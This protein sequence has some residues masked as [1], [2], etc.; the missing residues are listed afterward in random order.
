MGTG[1]SIRRADTGSATSCELNDISTQS[2]PNRPTHHPE[3]PSWRTPTS[4]PTDRATP[5]SDGHWTPQPSK[6]PRQIIPSPK[7]SRP[8]RPERINKGLEDDL[9]AR[10][11]ARPALIRG[12]RQAVADRLLRLAEFL[13]APDRTLIHAILADGRTRVEM[14]GLMGTRE[15][16]VRRRVDRLIARMNSR[17]FRYAARELD[18]MDPQRA[19]VAR[20]C[21]LEGRSLREAAERLGVST[22]RV[23][24][25]RR[26]ILERAEA[27]RD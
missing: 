7:P 8:P 10:G 24:T 14:A 9:A 3:R 4:G 2:T 17:A 15:I 22:H 21:I 19:A 20:A 6:R 1:R 12:D 13:G 18:R 11:W 5:P 26:A 25:L 23:T 16:T 27:E